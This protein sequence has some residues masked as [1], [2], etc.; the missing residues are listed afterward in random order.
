MFLAQHCTAGLQ[1]NVWHKVE[2][3]G[4]T[5]YWKEEGCERSKEAN[6][7]VIHMD[8][9]IKSFHQI[10]SMKMTFDSHDFYLNLHLFLRAEYNFY[11]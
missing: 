7:R 10:F 8:K 6:L 4:L 2:G 9:M 11:T 1:H 3:Q 5:G